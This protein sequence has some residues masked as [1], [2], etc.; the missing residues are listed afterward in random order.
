MKVEGLLK[1]ITGGPVRAGER[2]CGWRT[3]KLLRVDGDESA[4]FQKKQEPC[5]ACEGSR[6]ER[7]VDFWGWERPCQAR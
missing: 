4:L 3:L 7:E 2:F 5:G 6:E 1:Q